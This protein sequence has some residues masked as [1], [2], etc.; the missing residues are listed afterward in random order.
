MENLIVIP[1]NEK[2]LSLLK[3]L[4]QEM[5]IQ[6]KSEN[7]KDPDPELTKKIQKARKEKENGEL[8]TIDAE[9]LWESI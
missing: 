4:L 8:I 1:K 5:K 9:N 2:Q 6:F 7:L 3:S